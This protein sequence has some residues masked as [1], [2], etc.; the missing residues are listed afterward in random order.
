MLRVVCGFG[1][2]LQ[3]G[4]NV[5][6]CLPVGLRL[7]PDLLEPHKKQGLAQHCVVQ[8]ASCTQVR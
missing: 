8:K 2:K 4:T 3:E 6:F 1:Q 7:S 5:R